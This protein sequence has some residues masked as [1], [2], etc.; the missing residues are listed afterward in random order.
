M[1]PLDCDVFPHIVENVI[2]L[3]DH[4]ALMALRAG[5]QEF[6]DKADRRLFEHVAATRYRDPSNA[7]GG[8]SSILTSP[9]GERLPV[10][11]IGEYGTPFENALSH[12]PPFYIRALDC[13]YCT[14]AF[15]GYVLESCCCLAVLR[16]RGWD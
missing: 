7:Y 16:A 14:N 5:C 15:S 12:W 3:A 11:P 1:N 9:S 6:Q 4:R 8:D 13:Q 2:A 10:L